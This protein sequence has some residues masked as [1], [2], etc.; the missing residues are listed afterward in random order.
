MRQ[1][2]NLPKDY[3]RR[4]M[5]KSMNRLQDWV[6]KEMHRPWPNTDKIW[7]I[8]RR[9]RHY[10]EELGALPKNSHICSKTRHQPSP[11][12]LG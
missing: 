6:K 12:Q 2:T 9:C 3:T 10:E 5:T 1:D 7:R 4:I 11:N 8:Q